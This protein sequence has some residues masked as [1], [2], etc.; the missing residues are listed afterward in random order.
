LLKATHSLPVAVG[1]GREPALAGIAA[2]TVEDYSYMSW[3]P[4]GVQLGE[5]SPFVDAI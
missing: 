1:V 5:K 3:K 2:M 4:G